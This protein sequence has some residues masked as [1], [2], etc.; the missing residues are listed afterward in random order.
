M[1]AAGAATFNSTVAATGFIIGSANIGE[2]ELEILDG[3]AATTAELTIIDGNTSATS[4]T[5]ADADRVVMNDNGT[6]VQVAVTDLAA[7]FDDEITAMP[8]LTSVGTLTALTVDDV[9]VDGKVIVMTG[10]S[11]DTFTTT[12]AANGATSL[13]TVDAAAAAAHLQITADGTVDID[14]AGVL[15][16]DSGAAIN[17]EPASGSAILLDGTIS[18]DAGVVTGATSVTSTAFV[19]ALTGAAS[20]NLLKAGGTMTGDLILGDNV[21]LEIG[22]ASGGDLQIY[23][24]GS[25][26]YIDD[27]GAG[28]LIIRASD[29]LHI[30]KY[31]GETMINCNVDGSVDLYHDNTLKVATTAAGM[32]VTG[33]VLATTDTDTSNTGNV[34][35]DFAANQNFV[36]TLTGN[37]T[38]VNPSTEQVGQSGFIACIQDGTGSRTLSLGTD[39]ETAGA[40]GITL[41]ATAAATDLVPYLVVAANRILLGQPQLAFA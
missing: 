35:L 23:H 25:N 39:Y 28:D 38:L 40:A 19:G 20:S 9:A 11:G 14:S 36:L 1:S 13:V 41:T 37:T 24:D 30:Q 6:M 33:T 8:N 10:S 17:I 12:V 5:V 4:T 34:T 15:T 26:S 22:S 27:A 31:T 29:D 3:L 32:S 16:L 2:A 21:K 18:I 7:Y